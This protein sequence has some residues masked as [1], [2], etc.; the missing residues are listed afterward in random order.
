MKTELSKEDSS[1]RAID[2]VGIETPTLTAA[3]QQRRDAMLKIGRYS[4]YIAP[5]MLASF[6]AQAG[7]SLGC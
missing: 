3:A 5:A 1:I 2:D 7:C 4:A 6:S